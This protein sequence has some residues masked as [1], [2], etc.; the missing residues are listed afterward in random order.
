MTLDARQVYLMD[1]GEF[2]KIGYS[3][4][5]EARLSSAQSNPLPLKLAGVIETNHA[6]RLE[7]KLHEV[8]SDYR[9]EMG[10]GKEWFELPEE[11]HDVLAGTSYLSA[12]TRQVREGSG[13]DDLAPDDPLLYVDSMSIV[14]A[15]TEEEYWDFFDSVQ[16]RKDRIWEQQH[17]KQHTTI[18]AVCDT[19]GPSGWVRR[20]CCMTPRAGQ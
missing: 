11:I 12:S 16:E 20:C 19:E 13:D 15:Q 4:D 18:C 17:A 14:P 10:G 1:S 9:C 2:T 8:L 7:G 5:P 3:T 6:P